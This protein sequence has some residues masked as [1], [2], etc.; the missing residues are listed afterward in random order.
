MSVTRYNPDGSLDT[1][2][3]GT[4]GDAPGTA[5]FGPICPGDVLN[6]TSAQAVLVLPDGKLLVGGY[7]RDV[8]CDGDG[9]ALWRLKSDGTLDTVGFGGTDG[10]PPGITAVSINGFD[11]F[12]LAMALQPAA[13]AEGYEVI[14]AGWQR[15][16]G[17]DTAVAR[18]NP[19]GSLDTTFATGDPP[20]GQDGTLLTDF[21]DSFVSDR[22]LAV[23]V[24]PDGKIVTAGWT[25][26]FGF[27]RN[28]A[29][30]RYTV[31][32]ALDTTEFNPA[33]AGGAQAGT[34]LT[35]FENDF[36]EAHAVAIQPDGKIVVAG[37]AS[38]G[39]KSGEREFAVARYKTDG[40][41]DTGFGTG[42]FV[43]TAFN[44]IDDEANAIVLQ[45]DGKIIVSGTTLLGDQ[46]SDFAMA[47]YK[48]DGSLD[49]TFGTGGKVT[50]NFAGDGSDLVQAML[51]QPD[52]KVVLAG[53]RTHS[54]P[55]YAI[56]R[57]LADPKP[58]A[59]DPTPDPTPQ[60]TTTT[61]SSNPPPPP[62]PPPPPATCDD[63]TAPVV[64]IA[65]LQH[66]RRYARGHLATVRVN[67]TD[68]GTLTT[69]PS[70]TRLQVSTIK[71]GRYTVTATAVDSCGNRG[72][73]RFTYRVYAGPSIRIV[74]PS[75]CVRSSITANVRIT[76]PAALRSVVVM[77]AGRKVFDGTRKRFRVSAETSLLSPRSHG[78]AVFVTDRV[79]HRR[80]A[81]AHFSVCP[82]PQP[83][84]T[85]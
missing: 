36:D 53:W 19:D 5:T 2:F 81:I 3:G 79:G 55:D 29:I 38:R 70:D 44:G 48:T 75:N 32:G 4:G 28:W 76:S 35:D 10:D 61:P 15:V 67:A 49:D 34:V 77:I 58:P 13:N 80:H 16:E 33:A 45:P 54:P 83:L 7:Q 24:Q 12:G 56:A 8:G 52:G 71:S 50:T 31:D 62:P 78:L 1:S 69:D 47:R 37:F 43:Y 6:E 51:L 14:V 73:A 85:G 39:S 65:S 11:T 46:T 21:L 41:L 30:I 72:S 18:F 27:D 9:F 68:D 59:P 60:V 57:Y 23:A 84:F 17:T 26:D 22:G 82:P 74:S 63:T 20:P 25:S 42:G 66:T 40:A 64:S